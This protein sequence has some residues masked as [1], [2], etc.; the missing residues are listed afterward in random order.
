MRLTTKSMMSPA[1]T[2]IILV[3]HGQSTFNAQKRFQGSCDDSTLTAKGHQDAYEVGRALRGVTLKAAYVSPLQ[4][5]KVTANLMLMGMAVTPDNC[6]SIECRAELREIDL[7]NWQG[8]SYQCVR[9]QCAE[10]YRCWK[11]QPDQFQMITDRTPVQ[12]TA[13]TALVTIAATTYPLLELR[14]RVRHFWQVV[15]PRHRGDT[16]A[17]VSHSGTIRALINEALGIPAKQFHAIQ[18]S[19]CGISQLSLAADGAAT[20]EWMNTTV[21]LGETLPKL[22]DGKQGLRL[23]LVS[24]APGEPLPTLAERLAPVEIDFCVGEIAAQTVVNNL[25]Q[26]HPDTVQLQV[27]E[28]DFAATWQRQILANQSARSLLQ[29]PTTGLVVANPNLIRQMIG[30]V[31]GLPESQR[32][33][34]A[35]APDKFSVI[36][37]PLASQTAVLQTLNF[38]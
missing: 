28:H 31:I 17:I 8:L 27:A 21:H 13:G 6:P 5:A 10:E 25:L 34:L 12:S 22:K 35:I 24:S 23:I 36:H 26:H 19:N 14:D 7:P 33:C 11:E 9:E 32:G 18:Q 20:L 4:R 15:L 37:Y 30:L 16:I 38:G 1:P 29:R 2:R 3:R